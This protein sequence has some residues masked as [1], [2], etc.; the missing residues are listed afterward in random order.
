M[1]RGLFGK[2]NDQ[3]VRSNFDT[4]IPRVVGPGP[5]QA[6]HTL[7]AFGRTGG[8]PLKV[9]LMIFRRR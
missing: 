5:D 1:S 7:F 3:A 4:L 6:D 9:R 2:G 8:A